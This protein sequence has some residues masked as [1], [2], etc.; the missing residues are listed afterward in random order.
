MFYTAFAYGFEPED[1]IENP[2]Y[3]PD[4][5]ADAALMTLTVATLG[6]IVSAINANTILIVV[7]FCFNNFLFLNHFTAHGTVFTPGKS[8]FCAGCGN[9]FINNNFVSRC[10]NNLIGFISAKI[11]G[12][13]IISGPC[14]GRR[15]ADLL[16]YI[17]M[18]TYNLK[19]L[20]ITLAV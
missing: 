11:T 2:Y 19:L 7:S 6:H 12:N 13:Y 16:C 18:F 9:G 3:L 1:L 8:G 20:N 5:F 17:F 15:L 4:Q 14:A 10:R